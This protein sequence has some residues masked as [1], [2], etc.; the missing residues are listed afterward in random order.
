MGIEQA[1][2]AN[3]AAIEKLCSLL[4][5]AAP[6]QISAASITPATPAVEQPAVEQPVEQPAVEQPAEQPAAEQ[7][8]AEQPAAEQPAAEQPAAEQPAAPVPYTAVM[9][10]VLKASP[11]LGG[12]DAVL[13][14]LSRFGVK[15]AKDLQPEQYADAVRA[16]TDAIKQAEGATK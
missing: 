16:F 3:T 7:P 9:A 6:A 10:V 14:I 1:L 13:K 2:A 11:V 4:Q 5:S 12:K 8:A 15:S